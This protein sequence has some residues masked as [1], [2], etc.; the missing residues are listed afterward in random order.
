MKIVTSAD[1]EKEVLKSDKP[2]L[3][4]FF[5]TW[6]GPCKNLAPILEKIAGEKADSLK[7]VKVDVDASPEIAEK[8]FV[9]SMPT[10]MIIRDG[11]VIAKEVGAA[12]KSEVVKWINESLALPAGTKLDVA[13][14]PVTLSAEDKKSLRDAFAAAVNA[15]PDADTPFVPAA[16]SPET[17]I[18]KEIKKDLD[19]G[20]LFKQVE[21]IL[22]ANA[23]AVTLG[24]IVDNIKQTKFTIPKAPKP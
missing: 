24:D 20:A 2:V 15:C 3:V 10:M 1:F 17:T 22:S 6:C 12:P 19:G 16:G 14:K 7:I 13:P 5:A 8:Y 11:D 18:R 9:Q 21:S 23:G 4:D